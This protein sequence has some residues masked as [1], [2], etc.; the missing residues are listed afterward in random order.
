MKTNEQY[1]EEERCRT[2]T[3]AERE[4][5]NK[6]YAIKLVE[7]IVFGFVGLILVAVATAWIYLVVKK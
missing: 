1:Q 7:Q 5:S 3:D 6:L 2:V 4:K